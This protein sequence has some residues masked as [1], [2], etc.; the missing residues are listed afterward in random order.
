VTTFSPGSSPGTY[1][2]TLTGTRA[3]VYTLTPE[4]DNRA[5]GTP[6]VT[7]TIKAK[8]SPDGKLS[9][10]TTSS[11]TVT[12]GSTTGALLTFTAR[13]AHNN[14]IPGIAGRLKVSVTSPGGNTGVMV[15]TFTPGGSPGTY[16]AT[17][18]GLRADV[19]T[20]SPEFDGVDVGVADITVTIKAEEIPDSKLSGF[21]TSADSITAGSTTGALLTFTARDAH[22][23]LIPDIA[24]RLKVRVTSPGGD[25]GV[26][27]TTFSPGGSPGTYTAILTGTRADVY[28][29]TAAFDDVPVGTPDVTVTIKADETPDG[30]LSGFTT[31]TDSLTAGEP[32]G[33]LLTFTARDAHN[34]LIPDIAGRLKVILTSSGGDSGVSVTTFSPGSS[35]GTYT[36]TLTGTRADV[37]TLTPEFDNST[38]GSLHATVTIM[39]GS[40]VATKSTLKIGS[41][42]PVE[43][44][45]AGTSFN[46]VVTLQD[47][48][49]NKVTGAA[50]GNQLPGSVTLN[51]SGVSAP[52]WSGGSDGTF[53]A[54]YM[55]LTAS[56]SQK[57]TL[58]F[59]DGIKEATYIIVAGDAVAANSSIA[60]GTNTAEQSFT[61]TGST[62]PITVTLKDNWGNVVS[63]KQSLLTST[64]VMI[65]GTNNQP[66]S[67][68]QE[69]AVNSGTYQTSYRTNTSVAP[70]Q[71]AIL[72][73]TGQS[74]YSIGTYGVIAIKDIMVK[75]DNQPFDIPSTFP[76]FPSTGFPEAT[77]T[78]RLTS[79]SASNFT[80]S[81]NTGWVQANNG[82]VTFKYKGASQARITAT[83]NNSSWGQP[84]TFDIALSSWFQPITGA[85]INQ[86]TAVSTCGG[87]ANMPTVQ[88]LNGS[89]RYWPDKAG[90][91]HKIGS[92]WSEWGSLGKY[93]SSGFIHS[94]YWTRETVPTDPSS[95]YLVE[96][97]TG[98]SSYHRTLDPSQGGVCRTT[99]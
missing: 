52:A 92:L 10:F 44:Y 7:V 75:D 69:T 67:A 35:P 94:N 79:G 48:Y 55:A 56:Q 22:N 77:F 76:R 89:T 78:L 17:L 81:S 29:L 5:V 20:L 91:A 98:D 32:A 37:Y 84:L 49:N 30:K 63:G 41:G 61:A 42:A 80:W 90:V 3:D 38:V 14:L 66:F 33:A 26:S 11:D 53:T 85:P 31:S 12:A 46:V 60:V 54:T 72:T 2:A 65:P 70:G 18:T 83:P 47:Q 86:P 59:N 88:Q 71:K 74:Q 58:T 4:F 27:V 9:G 23:N 34:N 1:T 68:W 36:A 15:T 95:T 24:G 21:T 50:A 64:S 19:Y 28:T 96:A 99:F 8:D 73:L 57:A 39:A 13:D 40:A 43:S 25:S 87:I 62:V 51:M 82:V 45:T 6:D 97:G 16:T 93:G